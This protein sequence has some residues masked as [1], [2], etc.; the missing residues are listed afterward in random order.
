LD[1]G[2][3]LEVRKPVM[4]ETPKPE[5]KPTP[6]KVDKSAAEK[7]QHLPPNRRQRLLCRAL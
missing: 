7:T 4:P 3:K 1:D 5:V 2:A 6:V